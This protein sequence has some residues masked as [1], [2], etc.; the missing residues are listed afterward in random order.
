MEKLAAVIGA[1]GQSAGASTNRWG[2][3]FSELQP[4]VKSS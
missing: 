2:N 4:D 1:T 3:F